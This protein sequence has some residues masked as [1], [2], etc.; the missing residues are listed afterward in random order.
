MCPGAGK[1]TLLT[2]VLTRE[3]EQRRK[4]QR[5]RSNTT[6][7]I[8]HAEHKAWH[9]TPKTGYRCYFSLLRVQLSKSRPALRHFLPQDT[10]GTEPTPM[11]CSDQNKAAKFQDALQCPG[12]TALRQAQHH[13]HPEDQQPRGAGWG[14]GVRKPGLWF[15]WTAHSL[16]EKF[17]PDSGPQFPCPCTSE[18]D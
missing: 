1:L 15:G 5:R 3:M 18:L 14:G 2:P 13:W 17:C 16:T 10:Q 9:T 4:P 7:I 6:Y 11:R 12:S 8:S